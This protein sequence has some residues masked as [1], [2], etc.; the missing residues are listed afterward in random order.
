MVVRNERRPDKERVRIDFSRKTLNAASN[1]AATNGET[2][3]VYIERLV[4]D[5]L[6][7]VTG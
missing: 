5:D 3:S 4:Q 1:I 6:S 2:L 7:K